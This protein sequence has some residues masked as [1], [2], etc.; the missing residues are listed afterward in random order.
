LRT[1][2][3]WLAGRPNVAARP[4]GPVRS[5]RTLW[6]GRTVLAVN[7][8]PVLERLDAWFEL[9]MEPLGDPDDGVDNLFHQAA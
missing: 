3:A 4:G 5:L 2:W 9:R 8:R 1:G 7:W 6:P